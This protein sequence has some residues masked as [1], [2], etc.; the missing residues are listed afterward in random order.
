MLVIN[1]PAAIKTIYR[2]F[3]PLLPHHITEGVNSKRYLQKHISTPDPADM[4]EDP[5][6]GVSPHASGE[7]G[8]V[9]GQS[10]ATSFIARGSL[11]LFGSMPCSNVAQLTFLGDVSELQEWI[12][13]SELPTEYGGTN[14]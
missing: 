12:D 8:E 5:K 13:A 11:I 3:K 4:N 7:C 14:T 1:S 2:M 10:T 9:E 6:M